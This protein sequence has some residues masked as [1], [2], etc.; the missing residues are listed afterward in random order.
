MNVVEAQH[1]SD[2]TSAND[3]QRLDAF[4]YWKQPGDTNVLPNPV[5]DGYLGSTNAN[6]RN[7]SSGTNSTRYLQRGDY[8]RLRNLQVAYSLPSQFLEK[9]PFSQVRMYM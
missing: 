1:L 6:N 9:I 2:G 7:V 4:N 8:L 5:A 3:N